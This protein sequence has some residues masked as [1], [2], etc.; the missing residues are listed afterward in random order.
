MRNFVL[1]TSLGDYS[2]NKGGHARSVVAALLLS[3]DIRRDATVSLSFAEGFTVVIMGS[4]VRGLVPDEPSVVGVLD[5]AV[6][7]GREGRGGFRGIR[8]VRDLEVPDSRCSFIVTEGY[9]SVSRLL[10]GCGDVH[11]VVSM[12][13][14]VESRWNP[15]PLPGY[16]PEQWITVINY[17]LDL[18]EQDEGYV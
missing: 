13:P 11:V 10:R 8:I 17:E 4:V 14:R 18:L 1:L 6:R 15:L 9:S 16:L 7:W 3:H 12:G 2:R 5:K